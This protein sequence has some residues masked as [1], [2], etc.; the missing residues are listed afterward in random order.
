MLKNDLSQTPVRFKI[1]PETILNINDQSKP[2][3]QNRIPTQ[4]TKK[5]NTLTS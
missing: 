1:L 2:S 5:Q 4:I 3:K